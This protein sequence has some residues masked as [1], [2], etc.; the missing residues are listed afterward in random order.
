[1]GEGERGRAHMG[2]IQFLLRPRDK[3]L[4]D[5]ERGALG[6]RV[7]F[8]LD[9]GHGPC[10]GFRQLALLHRVWRY[11][12]CFPSGLDMQRPRGE[13]VHGKVGISSSPAT[14]H[15]SWAWQCHI[16]QGHHAAPCFVGALTLGW[17]RSRGPRQLGEHRRQLRVYR[18]RWIHHNRRKLLPLG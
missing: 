15:R 6:L 14:C 17:E 18:Y 3:L 7:R 16:Y 8:G 9:Q 2:E 5:L 11:R 10:C 1:M 13:A 4:T 12:Q